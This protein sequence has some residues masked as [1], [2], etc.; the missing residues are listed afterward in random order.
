MFL[1]CPGA[2]EN[3]LSLLTPRSGP[4]RLWELK[5]EFFVSKK[6]KNP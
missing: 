5:A 1:F 4:G 6:G 2:Y 3:F